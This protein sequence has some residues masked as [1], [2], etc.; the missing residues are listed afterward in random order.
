M[1]MAARR[2]L[3]LIAGI[4]F[5][6]LAAGVLWTLFPQPI[7]R[8]TFVPTT[9]FTAP[10]Q[11]GAP[12]Y[13][14]PRAWLSRP[15]TAHDP[16]LWRPPG[17]ARGSGA[18]AVAFFVPPTTYLDKR[19]WNAPF[20]DA[21]MEARAQVLVASQASAFSD[22][23]QVWAP[24]YRQ[25]TVGAFL[26]TRPD[27]TRALDLAYSD[28]ARAFDA[29]LRQIPADAPIILAG[30]SQ[31][32]FHLLRLLREKV[33]ADARLRRRIVAVYA[34]GWPVSVTADLP[35]LGLP[36]CATPGQ[37]GCLLSWESYGEPAD[38]Q[39]LHVR[40]DASLGFTGHPRRGTAALCINPLTGTRNG[41]A[42]A[43]AN[44]G[45][46]MPDLGYRAATLMP[47]LVPA[48]CDPAGLLLIGEPP[49]GFGVAVLPGNNYHVF[50]YA[51]F[52]SNIRADVARRLAAF[53]KNPA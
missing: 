23:A 8:W 33:A 38:A 45:S 13:D 10:P 39:Q 16:A 21:G 44:L 46:L 17:V 26:T 53:G 40:Y 5:L 30:H 48:R 24:R 25:A 9:G 52:W 37:T 19:H 28:V 22:S 27:A 51:L 6:L 14:S 43:A 34:V 15:G 11:A 42:P 36:A 3:Y 7:M 18:K 49:G 4:I 35:A 47:H 1:T 20:D 29:F 32:S 2:F 31:G 12:D 41:M 50:D